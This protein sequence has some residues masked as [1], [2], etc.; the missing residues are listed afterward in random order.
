MALIMTNTQGRGERRSLRLWMNI[1]VRISGKNADDNEFSEDTETTLVNTHGCLVFLYEPVKIGTHLALRH[2]GTNEEQ[3]CR[4]VSQR[5]A[6][7]KGMHFGIE[8]VASS[9][10]FWGVEFPP[11]KWPEEQSAQ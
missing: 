4:V 6:P 3:D 5:K 2:R 7:D 1:P 11:D 10:N 8:F 9:P